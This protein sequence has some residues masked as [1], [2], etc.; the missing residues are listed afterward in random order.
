MDLEDKVLDKL[1]TSKTPTT[2]ENNQ[3][4][5][6]NNQATATQSKEENKATSATSSS[7]WASLFKASSISANHADNTIKTTADGNQSDKPNSIL[8]IQ[9]EQEKENETSKSDK[10]NLLTLIGMAKDQRALKLAGIMNEIR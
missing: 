8:S 2:K 1:P 4:K 10:R 6:V 3:N 7:S 5:E 9:N